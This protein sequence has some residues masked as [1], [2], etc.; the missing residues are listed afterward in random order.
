[1]KLALGTAA[2]SRGE[3]W[4][5]N[6]GSTR[7]GW[8]HALDEMDARLRATLRDAV[9][10]DDWEYKSL[11]E[12][13]VCTLDN[14]P[15][16]AASIRTLRNY[17]DAGRYHHLDQ[18]RGGLVTSKSSREMWNGVEQAAI[19]ADPKLRAHY[20]RTLRGSDFDAFEHELRTAVADSIK[21]WVSI[22][23]L[24]GFHG[25]L[26]EDWRAIGADVL[27]DGAVP[28][29]ALPGCESAARLAGTWEGDNE[30]A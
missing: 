15:V 6:M 29:R 12:T 7:N 18:I 28:V 19:D 20:Q 30:L 8:G 4:P 1:M 21:R 25:V 14:D 17:A 5:N 22:V 11:L 27:P 9:T 16:W 26:G 10:S 23:C 24:F 13:W 2:V 3:G